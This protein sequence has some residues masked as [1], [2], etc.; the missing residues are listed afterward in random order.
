M[1]TIEQQ[2]VDRAFRQHDVR[3]VT[4]VRRSE[5]E[6]YF[7]FIADDPVTHTPVTYALL[8]QRGKLRTWADPRNLFDFLEKRG[9]FSGNFN[10][11]ED[12]QHEPTEAPLEHR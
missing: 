4:V 6:W 12:S 9:V 11:N 7:T 10:L 3:D 8:T 5:K 2:S 1:K